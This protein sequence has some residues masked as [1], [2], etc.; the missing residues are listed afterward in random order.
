MKI[1]KKQLRKLIKEAA[2]GYAA[3][4]GFGGWSPNRKPDFAKAWGEGAREYKGRQLQEQ[5]ISGEQAEEMTRAEAMHWPRVD[6]NEIGDLVDKWADMEIKAFDK[7][8]PAMTKEG[9]LSQAEA[10]DWWADQ[11]ESAALDLEAELTQRVRKE[12]LKAMKEF[13]DA[14]MNGSYE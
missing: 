11:V 12:A 13:S 3:G 8:D 1:S 4:P 9:E 14:L 10:K 2:Q 7:G 5:P 6:W